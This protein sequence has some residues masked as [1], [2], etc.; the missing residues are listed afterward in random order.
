MLYKYVD[1]HTRN[2]VTITIIIKPAKRPPGF[3]K[4]YGAVKGQT[5]P[6]QP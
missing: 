1:N 5:I 6:S 3:I 2:V 4:K